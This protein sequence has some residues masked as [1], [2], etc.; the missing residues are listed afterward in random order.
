[1][2]TVKNQDCR[3]IYDIDILNNVTIFLWNFFSEFGQI[4]IIIIIIINTYWVFLVVQTVNNLP[5]MWEIR[6]IPWRRA[7]Q[8]IPAFLPREFDGWR[9]PMWSQRGR[10]D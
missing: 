3:R 4:V 10:H 2:F 7:W 1:M 8:P 6:K 5:A 9:S